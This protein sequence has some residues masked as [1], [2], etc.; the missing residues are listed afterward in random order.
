MLDPEMGMGVQSKGDV[1]SVFPCDVFVVLVRFDEGLGNQI[2][3]MLQLM[4]HGYI[5]KGG[6]SMA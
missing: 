2:H 6:S 5:R 1:S 4:N 3:V